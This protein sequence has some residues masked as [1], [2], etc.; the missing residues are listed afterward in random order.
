MSQNCLGGLKSPQIW[1]PEVSEVTYLVWTVKEMYRREAWVFPHPGGRLLGFFPLIQ[2]LCMYQETIYRTIL[3][4]LFI[5]FFIFGF[6]RPHLQHMEVP[7]LGDELELQLLGYATATATPDLSRMGDL[8]HSS[9]R[10]QTLSPLSEDR[11]L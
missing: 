11:D 8:H 1:C 7:R 5:Y 2:D 4:L 10:C 3:Y 6:F 9:W